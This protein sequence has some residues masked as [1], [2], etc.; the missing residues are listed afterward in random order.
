[1][2]VIVSWVSQNS[3]PGSTIR[4]SPLN[5]Y[6]LSIETTVI[7]ALLVNMPSVDSDE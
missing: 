3:A 7:V 5:R 2:K 4:T 6:I 1:M